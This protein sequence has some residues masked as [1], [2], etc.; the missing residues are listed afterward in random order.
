MSSTSMLHDGYWHDPDR[1]HTMMQRRVFGAATALLDEVPH[2]RKL[3][4]APELAR[5]AGITQSTLCAHFPS[6]DAVFA[7]LYLDRM[8]RLPLTVDPTM[9]PRRRVGEQLRMITLLCADQPDLAL[10]C[11]RSLLSDDGTV[12]DIRIRIG[13]EFH[14]RIAATAGSGAWPEVVAALQ[15]MFWGALLQVQTTRLT[16]Q[17]LLAR[18]DTMVSL[19]LADD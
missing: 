6:V 10:A 7:G 15:T 18:L 12:L 13:E 17:S 4:T 2:A 1:R 9:P 16:C 5:R 3:P 8:R 19:I 11:N 14:R